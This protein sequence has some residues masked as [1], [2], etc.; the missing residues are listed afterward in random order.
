MQGSLTAAESEWGAGWGCRTH[1]RGRWGEALNPPAQGLFLNTDSV[2][3]LRMS[4]WGRPEKA[5]PSAGRRWPRPGAWWR[6]GHGLLDMMDTPESRAGSNRHVPQ[7]NDAPPPLGGD[8]QGDQG[9]A[10]ALREPWLWRDSDSVCVQW[11]GSVGSE[12]AEVV[13]DEVPL[14]W[15]Q[16]GGQGKGDPREE[17]VTCWLVER[18]GTGPECWP[19]LDV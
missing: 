10:G 8:P 12:V 17:G 1:R 11:G 4:W 6:V 18:A 2:L 5:S 9:T 15:T 13:Q 14:S 19:E 16:A 3:G 7:E